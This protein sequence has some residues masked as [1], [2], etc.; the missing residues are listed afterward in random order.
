MDAA[1]GEKEVLVNAD[2][3]KAVTQPEKEGDASDG[4]GPRA[5]GQLSVVPGQFLDAV[6]R[7]K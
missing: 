5:S 7:H 3:L 4:T 6:H 2:T 1:T